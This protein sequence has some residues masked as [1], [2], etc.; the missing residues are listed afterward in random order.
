MS[1]HLCG[2]SDVP[3]AEQELGGCRVGME[4]V[5]G[6]S[7]AEPDQRLDRV[8]GPLENE[9]YL[10]A[11][12][13]PE[14][15]QHVV[16]RILPAGRAA[17]SDPDPVVLTGAQR[18]GHRAEA[19]VPAV[20]ATELEP[21]RPERQVELVVQDHDPGRRDLVVGGERGE[22]GAADT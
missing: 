9:R 16:S 17:D 21:D 5:L 10:L 4:L 18:P 22:R 7:Q 1:W 11:L 13:G 3:F 19:V 12:G 15:A 8:S 20:A 14:V 6:G 2:M